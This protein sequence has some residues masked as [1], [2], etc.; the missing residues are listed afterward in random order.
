[1]IRTF[2]RQMKREGKQLQVVNGKRQYVK[3]EKTDAE[4]RKEN[5]D[6]LLK[7]G[8]APRNTYSQNGKYANK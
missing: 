2:D 6:F 1:M 7:Q 3:V 4:G 8:T 5:H